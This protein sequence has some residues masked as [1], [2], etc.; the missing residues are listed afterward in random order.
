MPTCVA[1]SRP[2]GRKHGR[3]PCARRHCRT[4]RGR[5][6]RLFGQ[7][8]GATDR[9]EGRTAPGNRPDL[10]AARGATEMAARDDRRISKVSV[11]PGRKPD[12]TA[13]AFSFSRQG[14]R[15]STNSIHGHCL[16]HHSIK[17]LSGVPV[18][19]IP[20]VSWRIPKSGPRDKHDL[21][22]V[23]KYPGPRIVR[24]GNKKYLLQATGPAGA[25]SNF[26]PFDTGPIGQW[27][28][29]RRYEPAV[30]NPRII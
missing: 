7:P 22:P 28:G 13:T 17:N 5:P 15:C 24:Y 11:A 29:R 6:H 16:T 8:V 12:M 1:T 3:R 19:R 20:N 18:R 25:C 27:R 21:L 30:V 26:F 9:E 10:P 4:K 2:T 14:V 23:L